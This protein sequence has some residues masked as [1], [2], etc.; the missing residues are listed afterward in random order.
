M[1]ASKRPDAVFVGACPATRRESVVCK[2]FFPARECGKRKKFPD[3]VFWPAESEA[4]KEESCSGASSTAPHCGFFRGEGR[5]KSAH[6][7]AP[8]AR[9]AVQMHDRD[10]PDVVSFDQID[11]AV[12]EAVGKVPLRWRV[13]LA[14]ELRVFADLQ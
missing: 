13:K 9:L 14:E 7:L 8:V 12:R 1:E 11:D 6:A 5:L 2:R 4:A 10:N 3:A